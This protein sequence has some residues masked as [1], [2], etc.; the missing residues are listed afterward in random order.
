[1]SQVGSVGCHRSHRE[2]RLLD[3]HDP[4]PIR[5]VLLLLPAPTQPVAF[6]SRGET[7]TSQQ[8]W[9]YR[10]STQR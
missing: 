4:G 1:M 2:D 6:T 9:L 8:S 7:S 10:P 5:D 3:H